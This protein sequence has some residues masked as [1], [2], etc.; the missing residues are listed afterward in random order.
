MESVEGDGKLTQHFTVGEAGTV[1]RVR[2]ALL[3]KGGAAVDER[4]VEV[5]LRYGR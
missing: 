1:T 3:N 2:V 4:L 5:D